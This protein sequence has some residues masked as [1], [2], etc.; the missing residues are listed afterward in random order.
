M[1]LGIGPME[2]IIVLIVGGGCV[3]T[4]AAGCVGIYLLLRRPRDKD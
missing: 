4:I 1:G 2:L 3:G